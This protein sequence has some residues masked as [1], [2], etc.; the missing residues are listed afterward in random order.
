M[1]LN[2]APVTPIKGPKLTTKLQ[3]IEKKV[4]ALFAT[5]GQ[6]PRSWIARVGQGNSTTEN[7]GAVS[8]KR[9]KIL[10]VRPKK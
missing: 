8:K 4:V 9:G 6:K 1:S 3:P 5:W 2:K 10:L 7:Q